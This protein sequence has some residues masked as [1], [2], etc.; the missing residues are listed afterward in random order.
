MQGRGT[1]VVKGL[2][3]SLE[4]LDASIVGFSLQVCF[5]PHVCLC[6]PFPFLAPSLSFPLFPTLLNLLKKE[7]KLVYESGFP[8]PPVTPK[9]D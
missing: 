8:I 6:P 7:G 1:K 4:K 5:L 9:P 2:R 3:G